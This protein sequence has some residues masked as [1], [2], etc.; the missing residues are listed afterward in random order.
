MIEPILIQTIYIIVPMIMSGAFSSFI[1]VK[2]LSAKFDI[3]IDYYKQTIKT[4]R[5]DINTAHQRIDSIR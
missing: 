1:T 3:H 2:I 4:L 5:E